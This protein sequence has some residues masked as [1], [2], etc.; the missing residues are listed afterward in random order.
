MPTVSGF[1]HTSRPSSSPHL[2]AFTPGSGEAA[3]PAPPTGAGFI[4]S[5]AAELAY[6][7]R[8]VDHPLVLLHAGVAD[9]RM[10]DVQVPAFAAAHRVIRYDLRGFGESTLPPDPY[11]NADDLLAVLDALELPT[12]HILG[13]SMGGT[14]ALDFALLHPDRVSALILSGAS[15]SGASA[16][17]EIRAG[18]AAVDALLAAND[19]DAAIELEL[20]MWVDGPFRTPDQVD[21]VARSRVRDMERLAFSRAL[22]AP[23]PETIPLDP[24]AVGRLRDVSA[25][26]LVLV[27]DL[28]YPQ[29]VELAHDMATSIADAILVVLS[30]TA[31]LPNLDA[32]DVFNAEVLGFTRERF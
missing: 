7:D 6:D 16:S 30:G 9:R 5:G 15:P 28:D 3:A 21:P 4:R 25:P 22:S 10:W 24:A 26:T 1:D 27:G 14:V 32:P 20:R 29:K 13:M 2:I 31:H 18:W 11:S 17:A 19:I 8:G 12:A 23:E